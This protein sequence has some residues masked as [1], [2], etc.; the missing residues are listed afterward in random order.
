MIS[1]HIFILV[2]KI[3][4]DITIF[5]ILKG[6]LRHIKF[7]VFAPDYLSD[8]ILIIYQIYQKKKKNRLEIREVMVGT[9]SWRIMTFQPTLLEEMY[10]QDALEDPHLRI[11]K[12]M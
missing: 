10:P 4:K 7:K 6:H 1:A 5:S 11:L 2:N 8:W 3:D 9:L 12:K